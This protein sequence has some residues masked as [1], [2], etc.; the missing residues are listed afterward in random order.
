MSFPVYEV[1]ALFPK[2]VGIIILSPFFP[3]PTLVLIAYKASW[4]KRNLIALRKNPQE[5]LSLLQ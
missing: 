5:I 3:N 2:V 4:I 1:M